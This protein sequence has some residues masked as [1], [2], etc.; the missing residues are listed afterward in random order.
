MN[1][2]ITDVVVVSGLLFVTG[3]TIVHGPH[4]TGAAE[5]QV[6]TQAVASGA[7][8]VLP[9]INNINTCPPGMERINHVAG[10]SASSNVVVRET[11]TKYTA[12]AE[13]GQ[14]HECRTINAK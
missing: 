9:A 13:G 3:C 7:D 1:T 4:S 8:T 12:S 2:K 5:W 14:S 6:N 11:G 10:G